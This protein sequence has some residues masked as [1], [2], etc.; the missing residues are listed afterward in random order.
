[1]VIAAVG[2]WELIH[3][4]GMLVDLSVLVKIS[5]TIWVFTLCMQK[6]CWWKSELIGLL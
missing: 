1:M 2:F 3:H 5:E 6:H 4:Q